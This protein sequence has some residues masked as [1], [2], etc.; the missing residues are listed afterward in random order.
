MRKMRDYPREFVIRGN[1]W[2]V[3]WRRKL[4]DPDHGWCDGLCD[5]DARLIE[6]S[7]TA[8][9]ARLAVEKPGAAAVA[10]REAGIHHGWHRLARLAVGCVRYAGPV[11]F[12]AR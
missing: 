5:H 6:I 10:S 9:A 11:G 7:S 12:H 4:Y 1:T 3:K 8:A 2:R